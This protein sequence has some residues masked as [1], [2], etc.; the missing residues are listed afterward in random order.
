M[1]RVSH[2]LLRLEVLRP[3]GTRTTEYR[4]FCRYQRRSV[5]AGSCT[6]CRHCDAITTEPDPAIVCTIPVD[7][8]ESEGA[9]GA[10]VGTILHGET[11]AI[12]PATA[13]GDALVVMRA[14]DRRSVA[15]VDESRTLVG[16]VHEVTFV[17]PT[18]PAEAVAASMS[19]GL[20]LHESTP[21]R[22]ALRL[23]ASAHLREAIVVDDAGVPLGTFRDIDGLRCI[24]RARVV[25][26][27]GSR[28]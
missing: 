7:P 24:A 22:R 5:P 18:K 6:A 25:T 20:A 28:C 17:R 14:E 12:D 3:D 1:S 13:I 26:S 2:P 4:V 16:V 23:L 8:D 11:V 21:V 10:E 15:V 19:S 27:S 9:D